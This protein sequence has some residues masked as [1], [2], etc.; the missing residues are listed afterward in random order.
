MR[1]LITYLVVTG[2]SLYLT[3]HLVQKLRVWAAMFLVILPTLFLGEAFA[4]SGVYAPLDIAYRWEPL[5]SYK[6][7][8]GIGN[9][10]SPLLV[11]IV[12]MHIPW[13]KAVRDAVKNRQW[14]LW[15][16]FQLAGEPL[17]AVQMSE[18]LWPGTWLG[19]A[20]PLAQAWTFD[21]ALRVFLALLAAFLLLR[22]MDCSDVAACFGATAWALCDF[23][24]FFLGY[25]PGPAAAAFP[26]LVLGLR[27][28][29][30][31][32]GSDGRGITVAA[33]AVILSA[34]HPETS[35]HAVAFGGVF[36]LILLFQQPADRRARPLRQA[37]V[38]GFL[39]VALMA[40]SLVP[41]LEV[42]PHTFEYGLRSGSFAATRKSVPLAQSVANLEN[43]VVPYSLGVSG[44]SDVAE[45]YETS[46]YAGALVLVFAAVGLCFPGKDRLAIAIVGALG[47]LVAVGL[48]GVADVAGKLPLFS[49]AINQR[50]VFVGA[51]SLAV[52]AGF[53][54]DAVIRAHRWRLA[55]GTAVGVGVLI[56]GVWLERRPAMQGLRM[57]RGYM[58]WRL[59]LE[60]IPVLALIAAAAWRPARRLLEEQAWI[61]L[62]VLAALRY[63]EIGRLYPV[64]PANSFYPPLEVL[65]PIARGQ[66]ERFASFGL[67]FIPNMSALYELEDVRGYE[68][69]TLRR[70][71]ETFPLWCVSQGM[72][73]NRVDDPT[74]PFL[75]FLNVR[76]FLVPLDYAAPPGWRS[77]ATGPGGRLLVNERVLPR[78][79]V[80][81]RVYCDQNEERE[82][83]TLTSIQDFGTEGTAGLGCTTPQWRDNGRAAARVQRYDRNAMSLA[84]EA[85]APTLVATSI[86]AWPGWQVH[87]DGKATQPVFYNH[88][89][90]GIPVPTG[91]HLV[92]LNY[93]PEGVWI[94]SLISGLAVA[95]LIAKSLFNRRGVQG[96]SAS[97]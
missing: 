11:D 86:P 83:A 75:S 5:A 53:G 88:A 27:R 60:L 1:L 23:L 34:G 55:I 80:P 57:A 90:L 39:G 93:L 58:E 28:V 38:S 29:A 70:L 62:L 9:Q 46:S 95:L 15:N 40:V 87:V 68:A 63:A 84:V 49:I 22:D 14:P 35:L 72:W 21:M 31:T 50:L 3:H 47:V 59:A 7:R 71:V 51:F 2:V 45:H 94:G 89:F 37:L 8:Y 54:L 85:A 18:V 82:L 79:F 41:F 48:R 30:L 33:T 36:F 43:Q 64:A 42:L 10:R 74:R 97:D 19:F 66:P 91:N 81:R 24:I 77:I 56:V 12:D 16:R 78:A 73:F 65:A 32:N 69:M 17:L 6:G 67:N 20:L 4:T 61:V 26:L 44:R 25:P 13:R 92:T 96:D 52:F 76:Y